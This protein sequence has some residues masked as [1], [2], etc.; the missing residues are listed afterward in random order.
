MMSAAYN[1][2]QN[3]RAERENRTLVD[4]AR[5]MMYAKG[6]PKELW[7]EALN[8]TVYI[9]NRIPMTGEDKTPYEKWFSKK[10]SI[11]HLR[12]FGTTCFLF[13]SN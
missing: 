2:Q 7:A 8:T 1:P 4:H 10:P 12:V 9:L 11:K 6:L 13:R 5:C 3:G